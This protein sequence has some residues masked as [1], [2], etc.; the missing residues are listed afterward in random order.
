M[1]APTA[2]LGRSPEASSE[3][4]A[5]RTAAPGLLQCRSRSSSEL[6]A[7]MPTAEKHLLDN[8]N[9]AGCE[10][11]M[12]SKLEIASGARRPIGGAYHGLTPSQHSL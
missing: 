12:D 7:C 8:F 9:V 2:A 3:A 6:Y 11:E 4:S 10:L 5:S 1:T